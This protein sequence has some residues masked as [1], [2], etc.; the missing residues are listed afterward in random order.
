M[1]EGMTD[2]NH[3]AERALIASLRIEDDGTAYWT[4]SPG[5]GVRVGAQAGTA[6]QEG[7]INVKYRG[8]AV[9]LHRVIFL[10]HHGYLPEQVDHIDGDRA[11][12]RIGNLRA[13]TNAQN[14]RNGCLRSTN[15]S[16]VKNVSWYKDRQKWRVQLRV[17]GRNAFF[18]FFDTLEEAADVARR[19]RQTAYGEFARHA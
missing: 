13:A 12:N 8:R 19:E 18:G 15:A 9:K 1:F 11:N 5:G 14:S 4:K 7:Y 17:N 3:T 10:A 2:P 6:H 16:G